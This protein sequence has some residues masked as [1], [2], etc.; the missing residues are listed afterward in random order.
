L[1]PEVVTK[2]MFKMFFRQGLDSEIDSDDEDD[3]QN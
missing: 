3:D 2:P 1:H